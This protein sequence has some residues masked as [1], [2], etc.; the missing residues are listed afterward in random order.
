MDLRPSVLADGRLRI[1]SSAQ[2]FYEGRVAFRFPMLFSGRAEL[3]EGYDEVRGR[4]TIEVAVSNER[5]GPLVGYS[6]SFTCEFPQVVGDA[7]PP[8]VRPLR[9]EQRR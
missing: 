2:R 3:I 1:V 5:F 6:G 4:Y 9:E 7:V 8:A